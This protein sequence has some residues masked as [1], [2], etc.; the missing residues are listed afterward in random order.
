MILNLKWFNRMFPTDSHNP[1]AQ[2]WAWWYAQTWLALGERP[3]DYVHWVY[4]NEPR[5]S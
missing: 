5:L 3:D 4:H 1:T 2:P